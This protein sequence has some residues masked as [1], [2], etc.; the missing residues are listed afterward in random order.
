MR[1]VELSEVAAEGAASAQADRAAAVV[2]HLNVPEVVV[3][4]PQRAQAMPVDGAGSGVREGGEKGGESNERANGRE[5]E[6]GRARESKREKARE[7][8][9]ERERECT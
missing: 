9:R 6:R 8:E 1:G 7:R 4:C 3:L 5:A 2:L